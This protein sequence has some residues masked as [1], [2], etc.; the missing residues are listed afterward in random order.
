[1]VVSPENECC[2]QIDDAQGTWS[3]NTPVSSSDLVSVGEAQFCSCS[4]TGHRAGKESLVRWLQQRQRW[5]VSHPKQSRVKKQ[6][7]SGVCTQWG[8]ESLARQHRRKTKESSP[9]YMQLIFTGSP[10]CYYQWVWHWEPG[11]F[12]LLDTN[13]LL[14]PD[15]VTL[16]QWKNETE[17]GYFIILNTD[18]NMVIMSSTK[19][20]NIETPSFSNNNQSGANAASLDHLPNHPIQAPNL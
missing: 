10:Q 11:H 12:L 13:N 8:G 20:S 15:K 18:K 4:G 3:C 17:Q 19:H 2:L 6:S 1:M 5:K 14:S 9:W 16:R 7:E